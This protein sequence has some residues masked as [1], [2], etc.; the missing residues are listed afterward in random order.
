MEDRLIHVSPAEPR[1]SQAQLMEPTGPCRA[2]LLP[3][4]L[5]ELVLSQLE[6]CDLLDVRRVSRRWR[7]AVLSLLRRRQ[8]LEYDFNLHMIDWK[9]RPLLRLMPNL[10][11]LDLSFDSDE[12]LDIVGKWGG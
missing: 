3:A 1:A 5:L 12:M 10:R 2:E 4:E 9:L 11:V 7:D 8:E 6:L